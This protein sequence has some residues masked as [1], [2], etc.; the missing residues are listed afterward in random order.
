MAEQQK[1]FKLASVLKK[2][3]QEKRTGTLIC[4]GE[5]T[6]QGRIFLRRGRPV[7]ARCRNLQRTEALNRINQTLLVSLKFHKDQNLVTLEEEEDI[8]DF[9]VPNEPSGGQVTAGEFKSLVDTTELT[10]LGGDAALQKPLTA[11]IQ[12]VIAEELTEYLGP[13]A[14]IFV[15]E[16][17]AGISIFD[18]LNS[19]S[20][21][22]GDVDSSIEFVNKVREKI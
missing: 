18:A 2:L 4:V 10:Q 8:S 7:S 15:S 21:D 20:Q 9:S 5:D 11:E 3:A 12:A 13:V 19:L 17:P 6:V 14:D 1:K 16:L 22:I